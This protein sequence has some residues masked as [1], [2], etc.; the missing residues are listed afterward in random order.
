MDRNE[1]MLRSCLRAIEAISRIPGV[2]ACGPWRAFMQKEVLGPAPMKARYEA[3]KQERQE[4]D[5]LEPTD[6]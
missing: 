4:A 3:V 5:G 1:D 6:L 2:D